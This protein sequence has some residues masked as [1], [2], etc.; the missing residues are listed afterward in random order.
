M[1]KIWENVKLVVSMVVIGALLLYIASTI[2]M[3]ELTVKVFGF[4]PYQV[5]TES[6]EPVINVND[7]VVVGR[8][9][10][11]EAE[12]G[13]IITFYADIDYNGEPEVVTHYI[14]SI[15][16]E[17][18]DAL[19]RTHRHFEDSSEVSPD[20]WII[21]ATDVLGTYQFHIAYLGYVI[22]FLQSI[23]GIAIVG[24]NIVI[25]TVI[26]VINKRQRAKEEAELES[27]NETVEKTLQTA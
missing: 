20:T 10:I 24:A 26:R 13:D 25:F 14:Y 18:D 5:Y 11:E 16:G 19:I 8:F 27:E 1:K 21:P 3:P 2:L 17:G 23:Y 6:M 22:G 9:D 15:E 12:V 7:V 4:Q